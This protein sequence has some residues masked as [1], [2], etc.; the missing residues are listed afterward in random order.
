M[1]FNTISCDERHKIAG[2]SDRPVVKRLQNPSPQGTGVHRGTP[3]R[4][5]NVPNLRVFRL[6]VLPLC[7]SSVKLRVL[8]G[9]GFE[10]SICK[11]RKDGAEDLCVAPPCTF[12]SFVVSIFRVFPTDRSPVVTRIT[13]ACGS[14]HRSHFHLA[15]H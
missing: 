8:C 7:L 5:M 4:Q 11:E 6:C 12:V 14:G 3:Q 15:K 9:G 2:K 13:H 1:T 10:V